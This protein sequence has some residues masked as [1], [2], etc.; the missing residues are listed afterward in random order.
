MNYAVFEKTLENI[1]KHRDIKLL[2]TDKK[3]QLA[4]KLN[5]HTINGFQRVSLQ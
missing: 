1:R 3:N 4:S 2:T 5:Y